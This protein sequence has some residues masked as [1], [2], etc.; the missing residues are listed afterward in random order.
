VIVL[1]FI[2]SGSKDCLLEKEQQETSDCFGLPRYGDRLHGRASG[3]ASG[4]F[5]KK[6]TK[7]L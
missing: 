7:K 6:S 1:C 5:L 3:K 4:A 2:L